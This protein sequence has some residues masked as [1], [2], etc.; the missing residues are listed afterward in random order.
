MGSSTDTYDSR[1]SFG[2]NSSSAWRAGEAAWF[3]EP[4]GGEIVEEFC[5]IGQSRS[6]PWSAEKRRIESR[7][8]RKILTAAGMDAVRE[9]WLSVSVAG[10]SRR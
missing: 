6:L 3:V 9:I 1:R 5:D 7:R 10:A 2:Y 8:H 4:L